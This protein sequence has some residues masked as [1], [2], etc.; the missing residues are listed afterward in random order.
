MTEKFARVQPTPGQ[1]L[2]CHAD[3]GGVPESNLNIQLVQVLQKRAGNTRQNIL[4]ILLPILA[5]Q[6]LGDGLQLIGQTALIGD[7]VLLGESSGHGIGMFLPVLPKIWAAAAVP[8]KG[9]CNIEHIPQAPAV[10]A[11]VQQR[12]TLGASPHPASHTLVPRIIA[13]AGRGLGAL[14]VYKDLLVIWVFV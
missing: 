7:A 10:P 3:C 5:H 11:G 4:K 8:A 14:G 2:I 1:E 12:D 6:L 9:V 13:G